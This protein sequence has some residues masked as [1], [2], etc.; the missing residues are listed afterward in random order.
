MRYYHRMVENLLPARVLLGV[1]HGLLGFK[2]SVT[3]NASEKRHSVQ[4]ER[5]SEAQEPQGPLCKGPL[6]PSN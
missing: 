2:P 6:R 1:N 4:Y 5:L 3:S